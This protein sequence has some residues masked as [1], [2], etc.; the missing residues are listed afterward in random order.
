ML[1]NSWSGTGAEHLQA[2]LNEYFN[3]IDKPLGM[4]INPMDRLANEVPEYPRPDLG[5][6]GSI[7]VRAS[8]TD[9]E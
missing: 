5:L 4:E 6:N 3:S 9:S 1:M 8:I 2:S 7:Q